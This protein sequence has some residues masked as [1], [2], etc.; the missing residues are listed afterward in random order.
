M[1]FTKVPHPANFAF[2][3]S[4][5][6]KTGQLKIGDQILTARVRSF[7]GDLYHIE[8]S[9]KGLWTEN[10]NLVKLNEPE[11]LTAAPLPQPLSSAA[12]VHRKRD[13]EGAGEGGRR[14][15]ALAGHVAG[16]TLRPAPAAL[17]KAAGT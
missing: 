5:D 1:Y 9:A 10:L 2:A 16:V 6:A 3:T 15:T 4:Y 8:I 11:E 7:E 14:Q 13:K 17:I 12:A